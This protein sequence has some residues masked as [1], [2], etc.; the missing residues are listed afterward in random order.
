MFLDANGNL[1]GKVDQA[2]TGPIT[3]PPARYRVGVYYSFPALGAATA[4]KTV[5]QS[6]SVRTVVTWPALSDPTVGAN[7]NIPTNFSGSYEVVTA[8][9]RN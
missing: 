6:I 7:N 3:T 8:I 9:D 2:L 1:V 5:I 4:P